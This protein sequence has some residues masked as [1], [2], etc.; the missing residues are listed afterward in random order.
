MKQLEI[1]YQYRDG[2]NW[3]ESTSRVF[4]NP[5]GMSIENVDV[6]L[7]T[8]RDSENFVA[9]S[10]ELPTCYFED[11]DDDGKYAHGWHEF[12]CV[13]ET[14]DEPNDELNRSINGLI[15]QFAVCKEAGWEPV[16]QIK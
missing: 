3:K 6:L 12:L 14:D 1:Y 16:R 5:M 9:E 7:Q 2:A 8:L 4:A 13:K 11:E 15:R 10:V